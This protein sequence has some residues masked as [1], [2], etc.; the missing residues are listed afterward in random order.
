MRDVPRD[1]TP[2]V[3][4][5]KGPEGP[6]ITVWASD[7]LSAETLEHWAAKL[8]NRGD[9]GDAPLAQNLWGAAARM[10]AWRIEQA[11]KSEN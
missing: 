9:P 2:T 1:G 11:K 7:A 4:T 5:Q 8:V 10:R 6:S 3:S